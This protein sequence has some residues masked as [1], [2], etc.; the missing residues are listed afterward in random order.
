MLRRT[1]VFFGLTYLIS[2]LLRLP[3]G[4][5]SYGV[6]SLPEIVGLLGLF[7][8]LGPA[9]AAFI[10]VGRESG[11]AGIGRLLRRAFD[12]NINKWGLLPALLL[13]PAIGLL[14][15]GILAMMGQE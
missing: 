15:L 3:G 8:V 9:I 10:L 13:L 6:E 7:A 4:L 11:R 1:W 14:T 12:T 5:R 2:W